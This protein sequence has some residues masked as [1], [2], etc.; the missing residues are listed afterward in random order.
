MYHFSLLLILTVAKVLQHFLWKRTC[1]KD[2]KL[3]LDE[4]FISL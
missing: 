4:G 1:I 2:K 3:A